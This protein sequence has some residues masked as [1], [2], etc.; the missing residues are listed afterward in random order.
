[1]NRKDFF[2]KSL[3]KAFSVIEE[4]AE[5]V[6]ETWKEVAEPKKA[7][8]EQDSNLAK[9]KNPRTGKKTQKGLTPSE[10]KAAFPAQYKPNKKKPFSFRNLQFPPGADP[11][12][13]RFLSKCTGCGDCIYSCPYSVLFPISDETTGKS[14]PRMDVN[15]N[16]CMLCK[17]FPCI[18]ACKEDALKPYTAKTSPNF[19]QAKSLFEHCINYRTE[20]KT[21]EACQLAC[22]IPNVVN[23]RKNKPTFSADCTG[24]GQCVQAC[25]TFPKA[26]IVK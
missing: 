22:P 20:E 5:E 4:G 9:E 19:G 8:A 10:K 21:C 26:I 17:D 11:S 25:P 13:K 7:K 1:M 15:L 12:G 16:A 18:H 6:V 14:T 2:R 3:S 24:C 23:F